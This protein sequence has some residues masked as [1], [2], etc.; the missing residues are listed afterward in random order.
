MLEPRIGCYAVYEATEEGWENWR[1]LAAAIA[2]DLRPEGIETLE[3][4]EAVIDDASTKRVAAWFAERKVDAL[5][6]LIVTW[7]FDHYSVLI[8]Q[9]NPVPIAIRKVPGIRT[10]SMVGAQQLGCLLADLEVEHRLYFHPAGNVE[11]ARETA[12]FLRACALRRCLHGA[13]FGMLGSRT[14]GMTPTA[15]DEVEMTRSF[16]ILLDTIE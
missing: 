3:A 2:A 4:P 5:H 15:I 11:T 16:G 1:N 8:Q 6:A 12:A 10:G 14:P 13:R 7:S 9:A